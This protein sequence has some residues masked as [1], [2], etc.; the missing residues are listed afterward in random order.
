MD[1]DGKAP[2]AGKRVRRRKMRTEQG[3]SAAFDDVEMQEAEVR[4]C[5]CQSAVFHTLIYHSPIRTLN[6]M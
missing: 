5:H 6:G 4:A 3:D 2:R 1:A